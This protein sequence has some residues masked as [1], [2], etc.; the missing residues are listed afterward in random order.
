MVLP[1]EI[2]IP[3]RSAMDFSD[4]AVMAKEKY[5][6]ILSLECMNGSQSHREAK[7]GRGRSMIFGSTLRII[8]KE[9]RRYNFI[10]VQHLRYQKRKG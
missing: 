2:T 10:P 8:L 7:V 5:V 3:Q 6:H 9:K 1:G 4:D